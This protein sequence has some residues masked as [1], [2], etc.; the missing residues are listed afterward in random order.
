VSFLI[1]TPLIGP[2]IRIPDSEFEL[3]YVRSSG[4][5]GQNVNKVNS[6]AVLRWNLFATESLPLEVKARVLSRL[7]NQITTEGDIVLT[8]DRFRDQIRNREDCF[9]KLRALIAAAAVRP[10]QRKKTKPS[11][12]SQRKVKESKGRHSEK[13]KQRKFSGGD[14]D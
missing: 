10:K 4:P 6:K 12:S 13:K 3:S 5:G 2:E 11:Y 8:S 1:V 14:Y 9:E 7:S